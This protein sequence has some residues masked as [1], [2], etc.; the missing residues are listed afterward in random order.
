MTQDRWQQIKGMIFDDFS[1]VKEFVEK[2]EAPERGSAEILEF[3]GP[4]GRM[5]IEYWTKPT[6][7]GKNVS[8]SRRVGSHHQV[9][10]IYSETENSNFLLAYKWDND[11]NDWL[12]IDLKNSFNL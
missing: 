4:L 9:D 3:N 5:R 12:E 1:D 10:Y 2:L 7:L 6:I 8:G 11:Q